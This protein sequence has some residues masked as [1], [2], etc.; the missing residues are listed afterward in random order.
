M[1]ILFIYFTKAT[2]PVFHANKASSLNQYMYIQKD[3]FFILFEFIMHSS[4]GAL[5]SLD[6]ATKLGLLTSKL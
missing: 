4:N 2:F 5:K 6:M 3:A 1:Y